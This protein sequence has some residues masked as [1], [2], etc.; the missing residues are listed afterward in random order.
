M[1]YQ[2]ATLFRGN[3]NLSEGNNS[4][5]VRIPQDISYSQNSSKILIYLLS[6]GIEYI[7]EINPIYLVGGDGTMDSEG[8]HNIL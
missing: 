6:E 7:S 4:V 2:G 8:A 1:I 5:N 3:F